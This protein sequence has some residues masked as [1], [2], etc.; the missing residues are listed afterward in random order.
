L[1]F[2][3]NILLRQK[4]KKPDFEKSP[5]TINIIGAGISG[6]AAGCYLQQAG[7]KTRIFEKHHLP[8][9]LCTSWQRGDYTFDGCAHWILGSDRG[10]A[11][12]KIWSELLDMDRIPFYNHEERVAVEL[13]HNQ[14][15]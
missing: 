13:K 1:N 4:S 7:F 5:V 2:L 6:L 15:K 12:Y 11:F 10:S 9:G 8:G 14:N 3:K